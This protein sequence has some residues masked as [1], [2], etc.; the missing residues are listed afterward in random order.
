[1]HACACAGTCFQTPTEGAC[2]TL[3]TAECFDYRVDQIKAIPHIWYRFDEKPDGLKLKAL[4]WI[5]SSYYRSLLSMTRFLSF[6][7]QQTIVLAGVFYIRRHLVSYISMT[8][9]HNIQSLYFADFKQK[10]IPSTDG[11][12]ACL[13][14]KCLTV[15]FYG[16]KN[17]SYLNKIQ[18]DQAYLMRFYVLCKSRCLLVMGYS[19]K[20]NFFYRQLHVS[21]FLYF[22]CNFQVS[23]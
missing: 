11:Y 2:Q 12:Y 22:C 1:M 19:R 10:S 9:F 23:G 15:R 3:Q 21:I 5:Y 17:Q 4:A 8:R 13:A 20:I 14:Y 6:W 7:H 16:H 18:T